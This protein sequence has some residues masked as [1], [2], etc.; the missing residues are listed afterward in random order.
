MIDTISINT[1]LADASRISELDQNNIQFGKLYADHMFVADYRHG[2]WTDCRIVPY[3]RMELSPAVS[4]LHYGQAIFEG[5]KAYAGQNGEVLIFRPHDNQR[6]LNASAI[7]MCM[8]ELPEEIFMG[9][10]RELLKV[11]K[12]WVPTNEGTSLYI[13]PFM[14]AT[15]EYIGVKASDTYRFMIFTSPA[16]AYYSEPVRMKVEHH[17]SRAFPGGTGA[18]KAAGNYAASLYPAL[19]AQQQGFHQLIW[20]DGIEHKYIE[21]AGT[22]NIMFRIDNK[23]ITSP[24]GDTILAGIT[25]DS[26]LTLGRDWGYQVEERRISVEEVLSAIETGTLTEAFGTGTA[27]TIAHIA[28]I[29][30]EGKDYPLPQVT[31]NNFSVKVLNTLNDIKTGKTEDVY[32]WNVRID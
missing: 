3:Q 14:F 4:V 2:Q 25:R 5:L 26:V 12:A 31:E 22:M 1:S 17:Y 7:R 28:H 11:D 13:R 8:P 16:G 10:L 6:R 24:T 19:Q 27:A 9:G 20:T 18:A 21:E 30:C 15:D 29:S 32:S 23:I